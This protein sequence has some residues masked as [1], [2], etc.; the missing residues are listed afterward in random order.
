LSDHFFDTSAISKHY[1]PEAGT[2]KVNA[3][4][5][6]AGAVQMVSRQTA[7]EFH[8]ALAKKVRTGQL[9]ATEFHRLTRRFRGD[10]AGRRLRVVRP[11]VAHFHTAERLVRRIG[12][13]QNLR[14]LD[15]IQL[16]VALRLNDPARPV[17]F[18]CADQALCSVAAAEGL[19]VINPELP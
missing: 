15:A 9:T 3:L 16:A 17:T 2:A 7:V 19:T 10:L 12:L 18:V 4:L 14:T 8:S 11:L 6:V 1:H 5:A 13:T